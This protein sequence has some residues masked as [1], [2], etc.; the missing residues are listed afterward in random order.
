MGK[1][2]KREMK[3]TYMKEQRDEL[4]EQFL[5]KAAWEKMGGRSRAACYDALAY[6]VDGIPDHLM[7][8]YVQMY[9]GDDA[10][11]FDE[12]L[13]QEIADGLWTPESA[14]QYLE[15][16]IAQFGKAEAMPKSSNDN[17][18]PLSTGG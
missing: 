8:D 16:F 7:D 4:Q 15:R 12:A 14:T 17:Q 3:M 11:T 9:E 18:P 2:A 5:Q 6:S 1:P 13:L 10:A